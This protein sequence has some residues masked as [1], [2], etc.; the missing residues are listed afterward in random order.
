M[1]LTLE[2]S[3]LSKKGHLQY[4]QYSIHLIYPVQAEWC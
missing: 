1:T 3:T 4:T 2:V